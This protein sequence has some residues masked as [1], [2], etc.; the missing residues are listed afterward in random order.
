MYQR[1]PNSLHTLWLLKG[2]MKVSQLEKPKM[3]AN[4]RLLARPWIPWPGTSPDWSF[5]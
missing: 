5:V 1:V 4:C 3:G 2:I